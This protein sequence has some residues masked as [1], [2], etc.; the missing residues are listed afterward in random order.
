MGI[1]PEVEMRILAGLGLAVAVAGVAVA[2][3][4]APPLDFHGVGILAQE[5]VTASNTGLSAKASLKLGPYPADAVIIASWTTE[6]IYT[7]HTAAGTVNGFGYSVTWD[8]QTLAGTVPG[9]TPSFLASVEGGLA[10]YRASSSFQVFLPKGK[11]TVLAVDTVN[12]G[13]LDAAQTRSL[14]RL[15][16]TAIVAGP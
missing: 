14:S 15:D 13:D 16:A 5:G 11:S 12:E 2:G 7:G 9:A 3:A 6:T 4:A 8:E 1:H 10:S